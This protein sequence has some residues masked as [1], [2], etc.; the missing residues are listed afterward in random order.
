MKLW[1]LATLCTASLLILSGCGA[2]PKPKDEPVI[3]TTLPIVKLTEN[4]TLVDMNAIAFEWQNIKDPRVKGVYIYKQQLDLNNTVDDFYESVDSRF[5]THYVDTKVI[6]DTRYSYYF[7]TF[8]D[9]AESSSSDEVVVNSLPV[10]ESVSWI[11][12][13]AGMPR[14]AK[15]IWRPHTNQ[16]VKAYIIERKTLEEELWKKVNT[17]DGRLSAEYID[18]DLKDNYTYK[19]RVRVLTYDKI[20]STPS[21]IVKIVTKALPLEIK[22]IQATNNLP[23]EIKITWNKSNE[24][25]FDRYYVYRSKKVESGYE[26]IAKLYNNLFVDKIDKDGQQYFYRV[27][28]VDKDGLESNHD[29]LSIQGVTLKK[30]TP[31]ALVEAKLI[32][33]KIKLVW[34]KTDKRVKKY[35]VSKRYKKG[36]FEEINEDFENIIEN[37]F[38]DSDIKPNTKYYYKIYGIDVNSI[39]SEASIEVEVKSKKMDILP[40]DTQNMREQT[41]TTPQTDADTSAKGIVVPTQDFN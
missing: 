11:H 13:I 31:P 19:Y 14:S 39:K 5:V 7:K 33:N 36:W 26:L 18:K 38:I 15:L 41:V 25:D 6:P 30:P 37:K 32:N 22:N 12:S 20:V 40:D 9:E 28:S 3:D 24:K 16:K 27:S 1:T 35:I 21:E 8:S 17:V 10:L 29:E 34:K 2:S 4:G 23:K